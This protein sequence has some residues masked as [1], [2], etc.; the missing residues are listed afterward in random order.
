MLNEVP[1]WSKVKASQLIRGL[2]LL[3][4]IIKMQINVDSFC[5]TK[6][7]ASLKSAFIYEPPRGN[8]NNVVSE[9]V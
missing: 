4:I 1:K 5:A 2:L 8:T 3:Y 9:Q 6:A 7:C